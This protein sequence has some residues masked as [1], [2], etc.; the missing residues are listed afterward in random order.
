LVNKVAVLPVSTVAGRGRLAQ[1]SWV[2]GLVDEVLVNR[3][4]AFRFRLQGVV[5]TVECIRDG[6]EHA[7]GALGYDA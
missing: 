5:D 4:R 7:H 2:S 1:S 3:M 6:D